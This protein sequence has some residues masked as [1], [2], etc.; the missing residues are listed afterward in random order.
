MRPCF[1][2]L[3]SA[4][5]APTATLFVDLW[6]RNDSSVPLVY[7][8][9]LPPAGLLAAQ[10]DQRDQRDAWDQ[11][12]RRDSHDLGHGHDGGYG[13]PHPHAHAGAGAAGAGAANALFDGGAALGFGGSE[14]RVG[15]GPSQ[16]RGAP[17][18]HE[19][20]QVRTQHPRCLHKTY[21]AC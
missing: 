6:L 3:R 9:T 19:M 12:D 8:V 20:F 10:R 15:L 5:E 16:D 18:V 4:L 7:G 11:W 21:S 13:R 1:L 17:V 2:R 14:Q